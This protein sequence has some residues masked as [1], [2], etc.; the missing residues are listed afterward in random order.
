LVVSEEIKKKFHE[1]FCSQN[2]PGSKRKMKHRFD[3]LS[4]NETSFF[5]NDSN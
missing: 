4:N 2:P 1:T 3:T 5:F